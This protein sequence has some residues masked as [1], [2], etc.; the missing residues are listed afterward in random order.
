MSFILSFFSCW[1]CRCLR[2][3]IVQYLTLAVSCLM[4]IPAC[5]LFS[6]R[7][8]RTPSPR[9]R[10][11]YLLDAFPIDEARYEENKMWREMEGE[12]GA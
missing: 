7:F 8:H 5:A 2:I 11:K 6:V 3:V 9:P 1:I 10:L 12:P 4:L